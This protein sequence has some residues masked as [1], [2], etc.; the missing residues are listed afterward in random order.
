LTLNLTIE[1]QRRLNDREILRQKRVSYI[2]HKSR[3]LCPQQHLMSYLYF[4][5]VNISKLGRIPDYYY[6]NKCKKFF[7]LSAKE[8]KIDE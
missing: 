6:C 2:T 1:E 8:V 4:R 7:I 5:D 3:L